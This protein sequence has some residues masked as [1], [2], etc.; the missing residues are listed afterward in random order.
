MAC[1]IQI[2]SIYLDIQRYEIIS[3]RKTTNQGDKMITFTESRDGAIL[4][5]ALSEYKANIEN[6]CILALTNAGPRYANMLAHFV[7]TKQRIAEMLEEI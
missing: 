7:Q 6:E 4:F 3:F 5:A 1:Y 2:K